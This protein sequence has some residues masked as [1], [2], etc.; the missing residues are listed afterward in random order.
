MPKPEFQSA[1]KIIEEIIRVNQAGEYA[2]KVIYQ[3]QINNTTDSSTKQTLNEMLAEEAH[4]L[5]FFNEEMKKR[6]VRPTALMPVWHLLSWGLGKVS[7]KLGAKY[8]MIATDAVEDVIQGHYNEQIKT[9][10]Y[11]GETSLKE[12]IVKFREDEL[13]HQKV[14]TEGIKNFGVLDS[15]FA[16]SIKI[17]CK[18]AI[19]ISKKV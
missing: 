19:A 9:L 1:E 10:E 11:A 15:I 3:T 5:I 7:A 13:H 12:K 2:A 8:T 18:I 4:H 14:A 16:K 17:G 6:G